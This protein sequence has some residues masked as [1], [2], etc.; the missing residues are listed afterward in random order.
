MDWIEIA[1]GNPRNRN[2]IIRT[3]DLYKY[4]IKANQH[5]QD[6]YQS[7][8]FYD[9][10]V[11]EHLTVY[12][13]VRA[14]EGKRYIR[15]L[16]F[17]I[18][19]GTKTNDELLLSLRVFIESLINDWNLDKYEEIKVWFSGRG[20]HVEIPNIFRFVPSQYVPEEWVLTCKK[21]FPEIV[22]TAPYNRVGLIR[23]P[24]TVN[25]K[26]GLYKVAFTVEQIFKYAMTRIVEEAH[27][28]QEKHWDIDLDT[29]LD[30]SDKVIKQEAKRK[31][32]LKI[33]DPTGVITCMQHLYNRGPVEGRRH[34]DLLRMVSAYRRGGTPLEMIVAGMKLWIEGSKNISDYEVEKIVKDTYKRK[35]EYG[36]SDDV[37]K[38]F[39]DPK[40]MYYK[41]KNY[42]VNILSSE[43]AEKNFVEFMKMDFEDIA[44]DLNEVFP[45][46]RSF[47]FYP[48]EFCLLIGDT[49]LGKTAVMQNIAIKLKKFPI[50]YYSLETGSR[51]LFRR[52]VQIEHGYNKN[53]VM[54]HY[55]MNDNTLRKG[56]DHLSITEIAPDLEQLKRKIAERQPKL[57][58]VDPIDGLSVGRLG[59]FH[60]KEEK[61]AVMLKQ[62]ATELDVIFIGVHHI[63]KSA[64]L[65]EKGRKKTLTL[66]SAKGDSALEQKAD[67]LLGFEGE[68]NKTTR[69]LRSLTARDEDPFALSLFYNKTNFRLTKIKELSII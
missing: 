33:T 30:F 55:R 58:I 23:V 2:F 13:T 62:I 6:L 14:F 5:K 46:D 61:L 50:D 8:Y 38:E 7:Y 59:E 18:D 39:C 22:D 31:A 63:P 67:K 37:M 51:L 3:Q 45:M 27:K 20:F 66:H 11:R 43:G 42:A 17:D 64:A 68:Q 40:C 19:K 1:Q 65:D 9:E 52:A 57:V 12:K 15:T 35:Y 53:Q 49:K 41:R 29:N 4:V 10:R 24:Q 28:P 54:Q 21:Y 16:I 56:L 25:S 36:C 32:D 69:V 60:N 34:Q 44:F 47:M 26:S 48:G